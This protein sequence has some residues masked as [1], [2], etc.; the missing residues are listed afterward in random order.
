MILLTQDSGFN[1]NCVAQVRRRIMDLGA[2]RVFSRWSRRSACVASFRNI[3]HRLLC[4]AVQL[5]RKQ[6]LYDINLRQLA[7]AAAAL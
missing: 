6:E 7:P 5:L 3:V 1:L 4:L 2:S